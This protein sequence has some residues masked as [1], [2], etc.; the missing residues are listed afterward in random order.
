MDAGSIRGVPKDKGYRLLPRA[1]PNSPGYTG[2]IV[3]LGRETAGRHFNPVAV[4][5]RLLN[6]SDSCH[7]VVLRERSS[8]KGKQHVCPGQLTLFDEDDAVRDFFTFGG[9]LELSKTDGEQVY[10][11]TSDAPILELNNP[12]E[13]VPDQ[14]AAEADALLA[15]IVVRCEPQRDDFDQRLAKVDPFQ[16][17]VATLHSILTHY[18]HAPILEK[19]FRSFHD[20]LSREKGWLVGKG[21]WPAQPLALENLC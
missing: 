9:S 1:H 5:L 20:S 16:F 17:Y 6:E 21:L 19:A 4:R 8:I 11:I 2:L 3:V 18:Q 15:K 13:S 14:L 10:S 7:W 12:R